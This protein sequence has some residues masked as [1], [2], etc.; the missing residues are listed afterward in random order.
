MKLGGGDD[1]GKEDHYG[2]TEHEKEVS[3]HAAFVLLLK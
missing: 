2:L 3:L 1:D